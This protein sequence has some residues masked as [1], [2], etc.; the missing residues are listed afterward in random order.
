MSLGM[1]SVAPPVHEPFGD[2]SLSVLLL[3]QPKSLH[4][5]RIVIPGR[6]TGP[7][8]LIQQVARSWSLTDKELA[9]L[10]AY[11]SAR[12]AADLLSGKLTFAG[13][14]DRADR[15]RLMYLV[16][17]TLSDLFLDQGQEEHWIRARSALLNNDTPLH[18]MMMRRI[19]GMI[20][21]REVVEQHLANR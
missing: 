21:V 4:T 12:F 18:V 15:A 16:H 10:L 5:T 11:P 19:P 17:S 20:A 13:N 6:I 2:F 1:P 7:V 9:S 3:G 8:R 14:E